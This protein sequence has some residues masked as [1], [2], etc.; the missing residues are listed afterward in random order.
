MQ[1]E[2]FSLRLKVFNTHL[3]SSISD[4]FKETVTLMSHW[5]VRISNI[6]R[7]TNVSWVHAVQFSKVIMT[8]LWKLCKVYRY[9]AGLY[10]GVP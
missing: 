3:T 6:S 8:D 2:M 4:V 10:D 1:R 7:H 5:L 9:L